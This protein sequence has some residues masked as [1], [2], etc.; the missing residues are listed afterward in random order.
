[1]RVGIHF[2]GTLW[3]AEFHDIYDKKL[4]LTIGVSSKTIDMLKK[5][6][7]IGN[8]NAEIEVTIAND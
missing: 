8:Q 3:D 1:M 5:L 7:L 6:D 2:H 4:Y